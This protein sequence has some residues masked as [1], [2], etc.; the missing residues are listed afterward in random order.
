MTST[1][2]LPLKTRAGIL[3]RLLTLV[4]VYLFNVSQLFYGTPLYTCSTIFITF[5]L[6]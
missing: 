6:L 2:G 3:K 1:P 4:S 5:E